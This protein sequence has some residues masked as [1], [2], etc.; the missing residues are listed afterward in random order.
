MTAPS[1]LC[2]LQQLVCPLAGAVAKAQR[3]KA[4]LAKLPD[5]GKYALIVRFHEMGTAVHSCNRLTKESVDT[6]DH[7]QDAGMGAAAQYV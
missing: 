6:S 3:F 5:G 2:S 1:S 7:V 4:V